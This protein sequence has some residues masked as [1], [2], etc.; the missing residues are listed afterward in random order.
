M[1]TTLAGSV[2]DVLT[3]LNLVCALLTHCDI[4]SVGTLT[5]VCTLFRSAARQPFLWTTICEREWPGVHQDEARQCRSTAD[6][7]AL[8]RQLHRAP[9]LWSTLEHSG[10][11]VAPAYEPYRVPLLYDGQ[12]VPLSAEQEEMASL[13]VQACDTFKPVAPF[14]ENFMADWR[15]L[16]EQTKEGSVVE[17]LSLCDF[18]RIR[19]HVQSADAARLDA[20]RAAMEHLPLGAGTAAR[21]A[22]V[23]P[24]EAFTH[25]I[26][27]GVRRRRDTVSVR[28]PE[29][30]LFGGPLSGHPWRGRLSRRLLPEDVTLNLGR[31]APVPP[32]P[33][34]GDGRPHAWGGVVCN[35][36]VLW[37][38]RW[39]DPLGGNLKYARV[40]ESFCP[41]Y[42]NPFEWDRKWRMLGRG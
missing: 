5:C 15:P 19:Q 32:V 14:D 1:T 39:T 24:D 21:R 16:L 18:S 25:A 3:D 27:D 40:H 7:L 38:A 11:Q 22:H 20:A 26:V 9:K 2:T 13:L 6:P 8:V 28:L 36:T 4:G 34:C 30:R 10:M 23:G 12:P 29:A 41:A 35:P 37:L 31:A 17:D 42:E 33:D